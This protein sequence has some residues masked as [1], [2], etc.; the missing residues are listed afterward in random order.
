MR[1][2]RRIALLVCNALVLIW[3]YFKMTKD[4]VSDFMGIFFWSVVMFLILYNI[5]AL[6]LYNFYNRNEEKKVNIEA[7]YYLLFFLPV[8][9]L[10]WFTS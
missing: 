3:L 9:V 10:Y 2:I 6:I 7:L 5:Y 8:I 1:R 4:T